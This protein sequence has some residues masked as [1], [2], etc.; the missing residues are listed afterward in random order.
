MDVLFVVGP[1]AVVSALHFS[2]MVLD[3][4]MLMTVD[5]PCCFSAASL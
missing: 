3:V 5:W 1:N 4:L 2:P